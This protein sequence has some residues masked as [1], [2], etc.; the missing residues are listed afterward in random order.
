MKLSKMNLAI[1]AL[2]T[3]AAG[4]TS[5]ADI[6]QASESWYKDAQATLQQHLAQQPN[7]KKAKNVILMVGDGNGVNSEYITRLY[8]GQKAGGYGDEFV[9]PKEKMPY[10]ALAKTY[11]TNGQT[12]DSAGT[13]TQMNTGVKTKSG[14]LGISD[15]ARRGHCEDVAAASIPS[16]AELMAKEGKSVGLATT[17]RVTHATPGAVYAHSGDRNWA[18][19][20]PEGCDQKTIA[21]QLVDQMQAGVVDIALGGGMRNF[22]PKAEGTKGK[23]KDGRDLTKEAQGKGIELITDAAGLKGANLDGKTPILGLFSMSHMAYEA[24]RGDDQPSLAEMTESAI[25]YLSKNENG[26]YLEIEGGRIDHANHA[27]NAYRT[28]TDG[29]AFAKAV[30]KAVEM[31]GDDTLIIV[32]ADHAHALALGGYAGRGSN[33]LGL[34]YPVNPD[35]IEHLPEPLLADDG[36]PYTIIGYLNGTGSVL[37]ESA[38]WAGARPALTQEEAIDKDYIQQALVPKSSESHSGTDVAIYAQGP[39]AHLFDGTVEQNYIFHVMDY[40]VHNGE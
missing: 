31:T 26:Y 11:N 39:W 23:R 14:V 2:I 6:P 32:T 9:T 1:S 4:T 30:E 29:E 28:V 40:A 25:N 38:G 37:K 24:D 5:A 10:L 33:I 27:G 21:E 12:P 19:S 22:I 34:A 7:V 36:K 3:C 15:K 8:M 20:V 13:A 16:F 35:G 17:A 18:A